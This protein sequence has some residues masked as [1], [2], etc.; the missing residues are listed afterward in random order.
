MLRDGGLLSAIRILV[1]AA[2][3]NGRSLHC[4]CARTGAATDRTGHFGYLIAASRTHRNRQVLACAAPHIHITSTFFRGVVLA[5]REH[6]L[7]YG[8]RTPTG[9]SP[10]K[11]PD[12]KFDIETV[13]RPVI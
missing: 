5:R 11:V 12:Y 10:G 13:K 6:G 4:A 9:G 8:F 3:A 2:G 1:F 7:G